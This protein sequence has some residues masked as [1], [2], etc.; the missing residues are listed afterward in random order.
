[1]E[2]FMCLWLV[3]CYLHRKCCE[4]C[5]EIDLPCFQQKTLKALSSYAQRLY[6]RAY[7]SLRENLLAPKYF[8]IFKYHLSNLPSPYFNF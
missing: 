3:K 6:I 7:S 8:I 2:A 4:T 1:M 5:H